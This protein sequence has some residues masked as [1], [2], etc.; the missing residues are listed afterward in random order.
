M[1]LTTLLLFSLLILS[2]AGQFIP[3]SETA[4]YSSMN[5]PAK[6][7]ID[8]EFSSDEDE[9]PEYEDL[10]TASDLLNT[11]D[12]DP[13][14]YYKMKYR[15]L[16]MKKLKKILERM[17]GSNKLMREKCDCQYKLRR[18]RDIDDDWQKWP[19]TPKQESIYVVHPRR[20]VPRYYNDSHPHKPKVKVIALKTL[21]DQ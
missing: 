5:R 14:R 9:E 4:P 12:Q 19:Q 18:D 21:T 2:D 10:V 16:Y 13:A 1:L 7:Y 17:T 3:R 11:K 8:N 20:N 15:N 6:Q